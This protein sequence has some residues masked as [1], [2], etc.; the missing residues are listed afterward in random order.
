VRA[1]RVHE[2]GV[3]ALGS[4]SSAS[5]D[6]F[7]DRENVTKT[8]P[9]VA[10]CD[11]EAFLL[12]SLDRFLSSRGFD[13]ITFDDPIACLEWVT[14]NPPDALVLDVVMPGMTGTEV[15]RALRERGLTTPVVVLT[16]LHDVQTAVETTRLGAREFL[17]KPFEMMRL[18]EILE[19]AV[20]T[21]TA[22]A[23]E[24]P[25]VWQGLI[26]TSP[27]MLQLREDLL[28]VAEA[29]PPTVLLL[30]ESGTGKE[31]VARALHK[32]GGR[33]DEQLIEVDCT[34]IPE[35]LAESALFG[36]ERGAF[37]G[38][39]RR[40]TGPFE[41]AG[42]GTVFLDEVGELPAASQA[43]LLRVL[44]SR[45][46]R[47]VGSTRALAFDGRVVAATHRDLEE[48]SRDG[49][50]RQ[51]LWFRLSP[52]TVQIPPLRKRPSD[53]PLL[54]EHFVQR[55]ANLFDRPV[56]GMSAAYLKQLTLHDWPGNVRELRNVIERSVVFARRSELDVDCLPPTFGS[57]TDTGL[58]ANVELP[59]DGL[60]LGALE[61]S[62]VEQA[63]LRTDGNQVR[64]AALLGVSR[65]VLRNRMKRYGLLEDE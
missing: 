64:A 19:D 43:R 35:T 13:V 22:P 20:R 38:A 8:R 55:F 65:F 1:A 27:A 57:A 17:T 23:E 30:G 61:Q 10:V 34:A 16:G 63:L 14:A 48:L 56:T 7:T 41:V 15:L 3:F 33:S 5:H 11:D 31:L 40:Q 28:R 21:D 32:A 42:R 59:E 12:R 54:A 4:L 26:G 6:Q 46:F 9:K 49:S 50:F 45:T 60:D 24:P 52:I 58:Y 2:T 47:R 51:D 44:E 37:T 25:D 39:D 18:I 29:D 36:H 62:L 53:I